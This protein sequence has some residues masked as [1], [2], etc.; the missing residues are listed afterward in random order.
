MPEVDAG[1]LLL[2]GLDAVEKSSLATQAV[3]TASEQMYQ[4]IR[5]FVHQDSAFHTESVRRLEALSSTLERLAVQ[6]QRMEDHE[7]RREEASSARWSS[8]GGLLRAVFAVPAVQVVLVLA[9][10]SW[11]GIGTGAVT[12]FLGGH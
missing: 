9:L 8:V 7:A 1:A 5:E 3:A 2:R 10:A 4:E 12:P 6:V 11:L